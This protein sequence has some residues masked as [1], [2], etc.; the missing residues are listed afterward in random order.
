M[1]NL[2]SQKKYHFIYK[3]TNLK[4]GKFYVGMHSTNNLND[5]YLGSGK[6]LRLSI[7]KNGIENFKIEHLEFFDNREDLTN[8]E[9]ELINT[10]LLNEPMCMNIRPGGTGG[11]S[12]E[13]QQ[14]NA[15]KS[16]Q[17]QKWLREN[18]KEWYDKKI[19][20][21]TNGIRRSYENPNR[22]RNV[23]Y[24]W[25]GKNHNDETKRKIGKANSI[26]QKGEGNS[27]FG[28][29]WI[30]NE[31]QNKKIKKT[32]IIPNGWRIGRI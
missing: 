7:R 29:R 15:I 30:T 8:R 17:K 2:N 24:D 23:N 26:K 21:Q 13:Q 10:E 27:Q 25:N 1:A 3:T 32:D 19:E 11:W 12:S 22:N 5:G 6:H 16:N 31:I 20:A 4:N 14:L 9:T 28:T 18:D